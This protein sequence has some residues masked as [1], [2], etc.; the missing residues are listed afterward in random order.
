MAVYA[1]G[2]VQGCFATLQKLLTEI[3]FDPGVDRVWFCGDLVNR[4]PR[5]LEVLRFVRGLGPAAVAVL[6]NHDLALLNR[7]AGTPTRKRDEDH[8]DDVLAAP[9]APELVEWLRH[10]PLLH[11]EGDR[12]VVHA[13]LLP[14]WSRQQAVKWAE[15]AEAQLRGDGW[16]DF[17]R[18]LHK[19]VRAEWAEAERATRLR[20]AVGALT[21][22]RVCDV[23][24]RPD[25]RFTGPLQAL[26]TGR[27]PWFAASRAVRPNRLVVFGHWAALGL[28]RAPGVLGVD[29]GCVWGRTLTAVRLD[30]GVVVQQPLVDPVEPV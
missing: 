20:L 28:Y 7:A 2:D 13:G 24:G 9:D 15:R 26:P 29:T 19:P 21:R 16:R 8:L 10:R 30:D 6:G 12:T 4:G 3:R 1:I 14:H 25:Y 5:S 18:A 27:W 17:V 11:V 23:A 22:I